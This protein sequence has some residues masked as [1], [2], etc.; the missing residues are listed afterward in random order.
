V[1]DL[2]RVLSLI[3]INRSTSSL[4]YLIEYECGIFSITHAAKCALHMIGA[5][6]RGQMPIQLFSKRQ[7]ILDAKRRAALRRYDE[8]IR[9]QHIGQ[10]GRERPLC[11][12]L[13][14]IEDAIGTPRVPALEQFVAG[15]AQRMEW[16]G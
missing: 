10:I 1:P 3:E 9:R 11:A 2:I 5:L 14:K 12:T 15:P 16:M 4:Q 6:G 13:V 7:K 8:S